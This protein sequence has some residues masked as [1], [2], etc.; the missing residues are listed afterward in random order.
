MKR[1]PTGYRVTNSLIVVKK[2]FDFSILI[3]QTRISGDYTGEI[4]SEPFSNTCSVFF[5][6]SLKIGC[7]HGQ[8]VKEPK[9]GFESIMTCFYVVST[10]LNGLKDVI[11]FDFVVL[12]TKLINQ[13]L[14]ADGINTDKEYPPV[15]VG[16]GQ[17]FPDFSIPPYRADLDVFNVFDELG[18]G[19]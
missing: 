2:L 13:L 17:E 18:C 3:A 4:L 15:S 11:P 9:R 1:E 19:M 10:G 14:C 16:L 6:Q 12:V 7:I 8:Y 5:I